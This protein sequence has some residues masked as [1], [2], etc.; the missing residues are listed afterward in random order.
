MFTSQVGNKKSGKTS[1][2]RSVSGGR[3][4]RNWIGKNFRRLIEIKESSLPP[5]AL[6]PG[7]LGSLLLR[8][9]NK[10]PDFHRNDQ[11]LTNQA[12]VKPH[13]TISATFFRCTMISGDT[14]ERKSI[15]L[16]TENNYDRY[17]KTFGNNTQFFITYNFFS[18]LHFCFLPLV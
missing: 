3:P 10:R 13:S 8:G 2:R 7:G 18:P 1:T 16:A 14:I 12:A 15:E 11:R 5:N 17:F 6:Q 4:Y 9:C